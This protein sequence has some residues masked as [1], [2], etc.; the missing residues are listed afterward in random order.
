MLPTFLKLEDIKAT[1]YKS[2]LIH[3]L[4]VYI[5]QGGPSIRDLITA[6][7]HWGHVALRM[8][9]AISSTPSSHTCPS[10]VISYTE[11]LGVRE[12]TRDGDPLIAKHDYSRFNPNVAG[13]VYMRFQADVGPNQL[14][15]NC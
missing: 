10:H 6:G 13:T 2:Q 5:E 3:Q 4:S 11:F 12:N 14:S 9:A 15:W 8:N 7:W 1:H